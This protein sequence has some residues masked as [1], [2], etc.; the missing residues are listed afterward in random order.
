MR[1]KIL[2]ACLILASAS[3]GCASWWQAFKTNPVQQTE[4]ILNIVDAIRDAADIAFGQIKVRLPEDKRGTYQEKYDH[5]SL[6]LTKAMA[7]VRS[8]VA[9]AAEAQEDDP[10]FKKGLNEVTDAIANLEAIVHEMKGLLAAP[11]PVAVAL[12]AS[13]GGV[14]SALA[15]AGDGGASPALAAAPVEVQLAAAD[16]MDALIGSYRTRLGAE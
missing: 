14:S 11:A 3:V 15:A 6:A 16:D 9:A 5:A 13:D 2:A 1:S 7:A 4:S 8:G 12:V 10:D